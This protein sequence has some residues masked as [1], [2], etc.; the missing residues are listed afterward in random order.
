VSGLFFVLESDATMARMV[1][2]ERIVAKRAALAFVRLS[3]EELALRMVKHTAMV[4][5]LVTDAMAPKSKQQIEA[6]AMKAQAQTH[7]KQMFDLSPYCIVCNERILTLEQATIFTPIGGKDRLLHEG[8]CLEKMIHASIGR[9]AGRGRGRVV[10][11][12]P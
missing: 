3:D 12:A 10:R 6:E 4:C 7:L 2:A 1:A 11:S 9:Y 8:D 5:R